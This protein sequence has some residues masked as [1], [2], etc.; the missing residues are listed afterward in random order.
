MVKSKF[1][2]LLA[3]LL[4]GLC[5]TCNKIIPDFTAEVIVSAEETKDWWEMQQLDEPLFEQFKTSKIMM[6]SIDL[7]ENKIHSC[8]EYRVINDRDVVTNSDTFCFPSVVITGYRKSSTSALYNLL[9]QYPRAKLSPM[10]E[11]CAFIGDRSIIQYFDSLPRSIET[12]DIIFDGCV[13][14]KG[15]IKMR[16]LL[17][18]PNTYYLVSLHRIISW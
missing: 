4:L 5:V 12:G 17:R 14:L 3:V 15:N 1:A 8:Y 11:N 10:K 13:D 18:E 7:D 2:V 16:S 6:R 9:A